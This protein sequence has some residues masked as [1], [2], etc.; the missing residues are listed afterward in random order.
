[1]KNTNTNTET[2][3]EQSVKG[4]LKSKVDMETSDIFFNFGALQYNSTTLYWAGKGMPE[5]EEEYGIR[6]LTDDAKN[7]L[8][9]VDRPNLTPQDLVDDFRARL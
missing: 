8:E 5:T 9:I 4:M 3:L 2:L 7:F 6:I 1:M